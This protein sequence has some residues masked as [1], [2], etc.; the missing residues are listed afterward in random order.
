MNK[1]TPFSFVLELTLNYGVLYGNEV[2]ASTILQHVLL[3][4]CFTLKVVQKCPHHH[5]P[6]FF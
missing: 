3:L 1:R 5:L 2:S 4:L 6:I